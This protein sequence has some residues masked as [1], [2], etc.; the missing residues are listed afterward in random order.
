[1]PPPPAVYN[2]TLCQP[3][4]ELRASGIH[5]LGAFAVRPIPAGTRLI[6]YT[7]EHISQ[8]EADRR[9]EKKTDESHTVLFTLNK[10]T[11]ID[12]SV[13]GNESRFI[14]HACEPNCVAHIIKG[15]IYIASLRNIPVDEELVYDY[16]L[17]MS[18]EITQADRDLYACRC[19]S[20]TC[21]GTMLTGEPR[22]KK[23]K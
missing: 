7:G 21:R 17:E 16:K 11:I 8:A 15:H 2:K 3:Y 13:G 22:E 1:M 6:E 18:G 10:R 19:G 20:A 23:K 5:G 14:N 12:A 9:A 4:F